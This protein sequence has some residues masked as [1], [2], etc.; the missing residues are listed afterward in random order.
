[1][2]KIYI[3]NTILYIEVVKRVNPEF[4][5]QEKH[6]SFIFNLYEIMDVH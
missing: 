3:I 2:Y 4:S 6:F 1:M 5:S